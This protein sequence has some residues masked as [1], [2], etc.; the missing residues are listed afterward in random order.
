MNGSFKL[1]LVWAVGRGGVAL[2]ILLGAIGFSEAPGAQGQATP[3]ASTSDVPAP[4]ECQ[5]ARREFPL[6][7]AGVGQRAA[8]TPAPIATPPAAPFTVPT[9]DAADAETAAAITA[10]VRE[11]IAC[12]NAG[13]LLRAYTLFTQDMIVALFGG[14]ATVD[15]EVRRVVLDG[16]RTVPPARRLGLVSVA[17]IVVLPDGRVSATVET[18]TTRRAFRDSL[19]FEQDPASGRWLIDESAPLS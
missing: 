11:A 13:D 9:G 3:A 17:D 5:V 1:R 19:I 8:A 2:L 6:F 7:P 15:P 10:T 4:E 16:L 12:R 18:E 14:P